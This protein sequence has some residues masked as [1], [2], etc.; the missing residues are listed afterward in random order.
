MIIIYHYHHHYRIASSRRGDRQPCTQI[1]AMVVSLSKAHEIA[2]ALSFGYRPAFDCNEARLLE[3]NQ[4]HA[5]ILESL[6]EM[7]VLA[8]SSVMPE[9]SSHDTGG[10]GVSGGGGGGSGMEELAAFAALAPT[11]I[12][13][14][15]PEVGMMVLQLP[16]PAIQN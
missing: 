1:A 11:G 13:A 15:A 6:P 3:N 10:S 5:S 16:L 4:M 14:V 7:P 12:V 8:D 2:F 9:E